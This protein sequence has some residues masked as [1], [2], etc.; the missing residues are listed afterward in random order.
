MTPI[1]SDVFKVVIMGD[2]MVGKTSLRLRYLGEG[3]RKQYIS[4]IGADFAIATHKNYI[5][6]LWDLAGQVSFENLTSRFH[7]GAEGLILVFDIT[8]RLSML[9]ISNWIDK[10][11]LTESEAVPMIVLGNKID[12]R[13]D[14]EFYIQSKEAIKFVSDISERYETPIVY[15]ETSALS[16]VN[17]SSAFEGLVDKIVETKAS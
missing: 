15:Y 4:T 14:N 1:V 11:L 6:Q 5:I 16:G 9:N 10:F 13:D 7:K 2:P 3:F 8:R 12:L 17:I